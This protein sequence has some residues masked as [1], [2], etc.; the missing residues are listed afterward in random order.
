MYVIS[1]LPWNSLSARLALSLYS[2]I[3]LLNQCNKM[4][5]EARRLHRLPL[6]QRSR[7]LYRASK[8]ESERERERERERA[9]NFINALEFKQSVIAM[10][11]TRGSDHKEYVRSRILGSKYVHD[12]RGAASTAGFKQSCS[13]I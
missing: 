1:Q 4:Y 6:Y 7:P 13:K 8:R 2:C 3:N 11:F 10:T 9:D 12:C 5:A